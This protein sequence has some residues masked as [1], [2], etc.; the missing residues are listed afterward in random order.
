[1]KCNYC[2]K[3]I[4]SK[5]KYC[6]HCRAQVL[7]YE[8][9]IKDEPSEDN[10][11]DS[12]INA[13]TSEKTQTGLI[14]AIISIIFSFISPIVSIILANIGISESKKSNTSQGDAKL[15]IAINVIAIIIAIVSIVFSI[16]KTIL[17]VAFG[18]N[19]YGDLFI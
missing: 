7:D 15:S 1:M 10:K 8:E 11:S 16:L 2:G 12:T 14:L 9:N 19:I 6:P 18:I 17:A 4:S 3:E 5:V 13:S